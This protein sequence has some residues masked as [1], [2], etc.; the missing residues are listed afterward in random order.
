MFKPIVTRVFER[1]AKK[2]LE[3]S[4]PKVVAVVGSVGK[5]STKSAIITVLETHLRVISNKGSLNTELPVA[6]SLLRLDMPKRL[7]NP[8]S[9]L[10]LYIKSRQY[11]AKGADYDV[12]VLELGIDR[13]GD[14]A[15]FMRYLHPDLAVVTAIS[16]E[17]ME[18]FQSLEEVAK[19]ELSITEETKVSIVNHDDMEML[20]DRYNKAQTTVSYG[21]TKD[22]DFQF[23]TQ[24]F[25][26]DYGYDGKFFGEGLGELSAQLRVVGEH[27]IKPAIAAVAVASHLQV[28]HDKIAAGVEDIEPVAGRMN[29]LRGADKS[30][31]LDDSYNSSPLA[32]KAALQTLYAFPAPARYVIFGTMNELGEHSQQLHRE[33][34]DACDPKKIDWLVTVG[35]DAERYLAPA[36]REKGCRVE[37]FDSPY[38]AGAF[39][40]G[41]LVPGAVVLAKG[42]QNRVFTEEAVKLLLADSADEKQLVR[43]TPKWLQI[44]HDYFSHL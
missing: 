39:I 43:Q 34:G 28:P 33:V 32:A 29:I 35:E 44:K 19:E 11:I 5:T 4:H 40:R 6:L 41:K 17:H 25:S 24:K 13:P 12:A 16:H 37:S 2:L 27:N 10:A 14:M 30:I 1:Q 3:K 9:W 8:F 21:L 26:M 22:C 36:A 7:F 18:N 42:S 15:V 38:E 23:I 20:F 31:I